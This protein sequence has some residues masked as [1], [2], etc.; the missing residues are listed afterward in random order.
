M[1]FAFSRRLRLGNLP[2]VSFLLKSLCFGLKAF[3]AFLRRVDWQEVYTEP[4]VAA[5]CFELPCVEFRSK[6]APRHKDQYA[7]PKLSLHP[8]SICS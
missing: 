3:L 4:V 7:S 1:H 5:T 2:L 6:R 8:A